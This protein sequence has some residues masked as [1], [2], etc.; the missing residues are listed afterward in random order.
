MMN[1]LATGKVDGTKTKRLLPG[2]LLSVLLPET[3]PTLGTDLPMPVKII[4][5][6]RLPDQEILY[7]G[8]LTFETSHDR[9]YTLDYIGTV[10]L[11]EYMWHTCL[12][13][14]VCVCAMRP[15]VNVK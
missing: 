4:L 5:R 3:A 6:L 7:C 10:D 14:C 13:G 2:P 15:E 9:G 12:Y 8:K 11:C 1:S